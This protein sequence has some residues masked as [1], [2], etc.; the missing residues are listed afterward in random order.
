MKRTEILKM[1]PKPP[2]FPRKTMTAQI[3]EDGSAVILNGYHGDKLVGRYLMD[4]DTHAFCYLEVDSGKFREGKLVSMM[5]YSTY[6]GQSDY[7]NE[8]TMTPEDIELVRAHLNTHTDKPSRPLKF[9]DIANIVDTY[10]YEVGHRKRMDKEDRRIMRLKDMMAK[11]P[12]RC[13]QIWMTGY[14]NGRQ[15]VFIML[16]LIKTKKSGPAPPAKARSR[17]KSWS[18]QRAR[19]PHIIKRPSARAVKWPLPQRKEYAAW[20][21]VHMEC[22]CRM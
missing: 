10:E 2:V 5:G 9:R 6:W 18:Q 1:P 21:S 3:S 13:R 12:P 16:F 20:Q 17:K 4:K 22:S 8:V 15:E 19:K 14:A 7:Q 11:F